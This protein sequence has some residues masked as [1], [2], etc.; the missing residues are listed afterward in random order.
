MINDLKVAKV[1]D[2]VAMKFARI[3]DRRTFM[4]YGELTDEQ[5]GRSLEDNKELLQAL[6]H[7]YD[8]G[9][10]ERAMKRQPTGPQKKKR[11]A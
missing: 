9:K 8:I 3:S 7:L 5:A 1:T 10:K 6:K 11:K 4:G 2:E